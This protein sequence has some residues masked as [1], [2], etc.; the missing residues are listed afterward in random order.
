MRYLSGSCA[1]NWRSVCDK[2]RAH[3]G[4][5][6]CR[7]QIPDRVSIHLRPPEI[8]NRLMPG[9]WEGN[10][11]KGKNNASA[12]GTLVERSSGYLM[13]VKMNDA[14]ATSAVEGFRASLNGMPLAARKA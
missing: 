7:S 8:E 2:A 4:G 6:N 9:H 12:V 5:V 10:L 11:I 14:T 1:R 13:L 3:A